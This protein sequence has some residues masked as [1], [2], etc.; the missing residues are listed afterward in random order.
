VRNRQSSVPA[1]DGMRQAQ[2]M[3]EMVN[4]GSPR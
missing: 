2:T 4:R 3:A 1:E